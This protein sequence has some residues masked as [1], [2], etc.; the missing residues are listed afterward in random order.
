MFRRVT[1][2]VALTV[3]A[4]SLGACGEAT[5]IRTTPTGAKV[6]LND[7]YV[8]ESPVVA[9]FTNSEWG[10]VL[11]KNNNALPYKLELDGYESKEGRVPVRVSAFRIW[12]NVNAVFIPYIFRSS[13]RP[14]RNE[15]DFDLVAVGGGGRPSDARLPADVRERLHKLEGLRDQGVVTP[16][17]YEQLRIQ[18]LKDALAPGA[19][20]GATSH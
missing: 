9:H 19:P 7:K 20:E 16:R 17:E 3:C 11:R 4:I 6:W 10:D 13:F 15:Y 5:R 14:P 1:P 8:G 18:I 12:A 2:W